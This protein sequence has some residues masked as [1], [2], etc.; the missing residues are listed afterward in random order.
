MAASRSALLETLSTQA[1]PP[2]GL[3]DGA[4][5]NVIQKMDEVYSRLIEDEVE[6]EKKNAQL[7]QS[8]QFIESVLS[9]MTDVLVVC[10]EAGRIEQANAALCRLVGQSEAQLRGQPLRALLADEA[11]RQRHDQALQA[12]RQEQEVQE[13]E[14][15]LRDAQQQ[16]VPVDARCTPRT[17]PHGRRVGWVWVGR[18]MAE[19]KR[20]Y[21][22]LQQAHAALQTTQQQ[23]I[24]SEKMA[25]LGQLVAGVAHELNNPISFVLGNVHA[26]QRYCQRLQTY[27]EAL[28]NERLPNGPE[29]TALRSQLR[30]AHVLADL[31]SLIDGTLE[32]ATRTAD[33][34][35]GLKQF[36]ARDC[37][38]RSPVDLNTVVERALRWMHKALPAHVQV[39]WQAQQP[40]QVLGSDGQ[41]QQVVMNLLQNAFDALANTPESAGEV[42]IAIEQEDPYLCLRVRDNGPGIATEHLGRLFDPF[43]T[44]K[45]VGKGTGLGLSISYGIV[46][47]HGG[48]LSARKLEPRG[49]EFVLKLPVARDV[50]APT[51]EALPPGPPSPPA[52][53]PRA[54]APPQRP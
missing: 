6:L 34:V 8:H 28:E 53:A 52:Q 12:S 33:I 51:P 54:K 25:S 38:A 39:H 43:F 9:A 2:E 17:G 32:G 50:A 4:W 7:E 29:L 44:T 5:V 49:A 42:R 24:H 3:D 13:V 31:P 1:A 15:Q 40:A 36:S 37:E 20:A 48:Q 14:L 11:S 26:M 16:G 21:R 47:Q 46:E 18:P 35:H 27:I 10:D 23:L 22:D 41:L 19:L 30:I 45:P